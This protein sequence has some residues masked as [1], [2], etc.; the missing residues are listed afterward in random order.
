VHAI[1]IDNW[2]EKSQIESAI[3]TCISYRSGLDLVITVLP[4]PNAIFEEFGELPIL[5][6]EISNNSIG[7]SSPISFSPSVPAVPATQNHLSPSIGPTISLSSNID[8]FKM[9]INLNEVV[10]TQAFE[11]VKQ[12]RM[13]NVYFNYNKKAEDNFQERCYYDTLRASVENLSQSLH[14]KWTESNVVVNSLTCDFCVGNGRKLA[15]ELTYTLTYL[16][17]AAGELVVGQNLKL[18]PNSVANNVI[19]INLLFLVWPF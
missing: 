13:I 9:L 8:P 15:Q 4:L 6:D 7:S 11:K 1:V 19:K 16:C 10:Y 3:K 14:K 5:I 18:T 2:N 17:S 12:G